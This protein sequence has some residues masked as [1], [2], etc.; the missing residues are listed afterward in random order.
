M[1]RRPSQASEMARKAFEKSGSTLSA[2]VLAKKYGVALT[3]I[4]RAAW[5]KKPHSTQTQTGEKQ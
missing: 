2:K 3:T 1:S 5:F 4:Y